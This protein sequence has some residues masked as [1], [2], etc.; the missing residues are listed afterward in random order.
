M[1]LSFFLN[2]LDVYNET[3]NVLSSPKG[4]RRFKVWKKMRQEGI[5]KFKNYRK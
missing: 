2:L 3:K 1:Q 5:K 4:L